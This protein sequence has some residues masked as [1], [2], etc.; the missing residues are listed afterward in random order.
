MGWSEG[1]GLG[2]NETGI[3]DCVQIKRRD[4]NIGLGTK[5]LSGNNFS[6]N[7][8]WWDE[9]YNKSIKKLSIKVNTHKHKKEV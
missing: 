5:S 9:A 4:D 2:K 8:S 6:W 1:K 7:D 3:I